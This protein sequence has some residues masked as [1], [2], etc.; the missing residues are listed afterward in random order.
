MTVEEFLAQTRN[1]DTIERSVELWL[2]LDRRERNAHRKMDLV[3]RSA[4]DKANNRAARLRTAKAKIDALAAS[5]VAPDGK[6]Y[7]THQCSEPSCLRGAS[8]GKAFCVVHESKPT[9]DF[10]FPQSAPR[11]QQGPQ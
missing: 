4:K 9:E 6:P 2:R 1:T 5:G 11:A 3:E 10:R 8:P 7:T